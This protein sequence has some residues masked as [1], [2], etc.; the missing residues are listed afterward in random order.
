MKN[1]VRRSG[2]TL[3]E[4]LVTV[5]VVAVLAAVVVPAVTQ[6]VSKG[7]APATQQDLIAIRN[8][9]TQYVADTRKNPTSLYQLTT[10][11][12]DAGYKGPYLQA[13]LSANTAT[14]VFYSGGL[15]VE[16]GPDIQSAGGYLE[17]PLTFKDA[18]ATCADLYALDKSL[19][20]GTGDGTTGSTSTA[21]DAAQG[22][23]H[24]T[25]SECLATTTLVSAVPSLRVRLAAI[26]S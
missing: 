11:S 17:A 24:W 22:V 19:D 25:P 20:A 16:I 5:T 18:S 13:S 10:A 2:F 7:D 3:P 15:R 4:I 12:S 8:A 23:I 21:A 6:Y 26:G 9:V 1:R 14:G